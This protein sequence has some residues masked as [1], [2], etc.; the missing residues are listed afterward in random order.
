VT[1][2][3]FVIGLAVD[4]VSNAAAVCTV[5]VAQGLRRPRRELVQR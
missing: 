3:A 2:V 5:P 1:G 4:A